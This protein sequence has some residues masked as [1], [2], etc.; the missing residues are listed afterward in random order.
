MKLLRVFIRDHITHEIQDVRNDDSAE[1]GPDFKVSRTAHEQFECIWDLIE[2]RIGHKQRLT[3]NEQQK[4]LR[5][6]RKHQ[7]QEQSAKRRH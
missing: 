6:A 7:Q 3:Q 4:R 2:E 5:R 1:S